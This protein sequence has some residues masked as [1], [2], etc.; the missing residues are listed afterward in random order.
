M[1]EASDPVTDFREVITN[2]GCIACG[3]KHEVVIEPNVQT[4][5]EL[6]DLSNLTFEEQATAK[7]LLYK[8]H[9]VFSRNNTDL[10]RTALILSL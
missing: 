4:C 8:Y 2:E 1:I 7:A 3:Q 5:F 6:V 10:G 9:N